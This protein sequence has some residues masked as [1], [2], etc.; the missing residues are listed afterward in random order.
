MLSEADG[1]LLLARLFQARGYQISRNVPIREQSLS[2]TADG[3][4]ERA[5]VGFEYLTHEAGDQLDLPPQ[6]RAE[7]ERRIQQ[8]DLYFFLIDERQIESADE[9]AWAAERFLDHVER[10]RASDAEQP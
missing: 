6:M 4:D 10:L 9:L 1:C 8:G 3:W 7:L 2:F 5:R